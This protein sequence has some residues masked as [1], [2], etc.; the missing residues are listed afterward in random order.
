MS[1]EFVEGL[2]ASA[3][4]SRSW[5]NRLKNILFPVSMSRGNKAIAIVHLVVGAAAFIAFVVTGKFMRID[6]PDKGSIPPEL[7]ML[8]RSRH[9]YILFSGLIHLVLGIYLQ[10][11]P[12]TWRRS[13]QYLGSLLLVISS[14]LLLWAF[15]VETYQ[16]QHFSDISRWGIY[17]SLAGVGAHLIGGTTMRN[18]EQ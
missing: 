15:I 10:I 17:L 5:Q 14:G 8:M 13:L 4:V 12:Q 9:I 2:G 3:K 1:I 18:H 11:G 6:F 7:R 16:L